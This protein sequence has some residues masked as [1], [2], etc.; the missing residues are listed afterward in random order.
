MPFTLPGLPFLETNVPSTVPYGPRPLEPASR[1]RRKFPDL[2]RVAITSVT[3]PREDDFALPGLNQA[4][5]LGGMISTEKRGTTIVVTH[6]PIRTM[7]TQCANH[8]GT[9]AI[10]LDGYARPAVCGGGPLKPF[11]DQSVGVGQFFMA[12]ASTQYGTGQL[13]KGYVYGVVPYQGPDTFIGTWT[14]HPGSGIPG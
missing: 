1:R 5:Q 12:K 13:H 7:S 8:A 3:L 9:M 10:G 14:G 4:G 6:H 11:F 2:C